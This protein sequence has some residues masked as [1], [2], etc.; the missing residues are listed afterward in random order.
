MCIL[1]NFQFVKLLFMFLC[2]CF[3]V[4]VILFVS[5]LC[6]YFQVIYFYIILSS[7]S[8]PYNWSSPYL[9]AMSSGL[10]CPSTVRWRES[11]PADV[12]FLHDSCNPQAHLDQRRQRS[13]FHYNR[14]C[15]C[16]HAGLHGIPYHSLLDERPRH[17]DRNSWHCSCSISSFSNIL[18]VLGKLCWSWHRCH[19]CAII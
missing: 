14:H 17:F 10:P 5:L 18:E 2:C 9:W 12:H 11:H 1:Q 13:S 6:S 16:S 3:L 15:G 7:F 8:G 4:V 19:P